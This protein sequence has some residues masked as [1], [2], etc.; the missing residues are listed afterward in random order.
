LKQKEK[1]VAESVAD[2]AG[3]I[4]VQTVQDPPSSADPD[5][6]PPPS[7][8]R[9]TCDQGSDP[10]EAGTHL[11]YLLFELQQAWVR[12]R[13]SHVDLVEQLARQLGRLVRGLVAAGARDELEKAVTAP[14][15]E[16][17]ESARSGHYGE[18]LSETNEEL[19]VN[20]GLADPVKVREGLVRQ[21]FQEIDEVRATIMRA[22]DEG[23]QTMLSLGQV[24][25]EGWRRPDI[26]R[27]MDSKGQDWRGSS[28]Q[29]EA[30]LTTVEGAQPRQ[31]E[32]SGDGATVCC[33][34][35]THRLLSK[36]VRPPP[37]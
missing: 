6:R 34:P 14:L 33:E 22:L 27:F 15:L 21:V 24:V 28:G 4:R 13:H 37:Y 20:L 3:G 19:A 29:D 17:V 32:A 5:R 16:L 11:N 36:G 35:T 23:G 25:D 12:P 2:H 8:E 18:S 26:Y 1:V 31:S 30:R 9:V 7:S 10:Y